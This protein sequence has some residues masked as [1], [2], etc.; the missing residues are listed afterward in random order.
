[1]SSVYFDK[2]T[3]TQR[4]K[5]TCPRS[6]SKGETEPGPGHVYFHAAFEVQTYFCCLLDRDF[7]LSPFYWTYLSSPYPGHSDLP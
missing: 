5:G 7:T 4:E 6:Q 1:M 2:E 3:E